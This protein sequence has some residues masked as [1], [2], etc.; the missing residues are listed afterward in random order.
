MLAR[1]F[2]RL[3]AILPLFVVAACSDSGLFN[4]NQNESATRLALRPYYG[5][6]DAAQSAVDINLIRLT[7]TVLPSGPTFVVDQ[8]VDPN[9]STW[10]LP[11]DVPPNSELSVLVELINRAPGGAEVVHFSG[12][13]PVI[14]VTSG[15]QPPTAPIP[16]FPGPAGNL[17]VSAVSISPRDQSLL[18][19]SNVS[20]A[21]TVTGGTN[22]QVRWSSNNESVAT[23]NA[24]GVVSGVRPGVA[25]ITAQ[26]GPRSDN[27]NVTVGARATRVEL[28]PTAATLT[29][30][31]QQQAFTARVLDSRNEV[32]PGLTVTFSIADATIASQGAPGVFRAL[33]NGK[34]TVTASA[35]QGTSTI[36]GS[37]DLTVDQRAT[38]IT[39]T[40]T[41]RVFESFGATQQFTI[42]ARDANGRPVPATAVTWRS[43]NPSVATVNASGLV[44]SVAPGTTN[45]IAESGTTSAQAEVTV[46]QRASSIT[47]T[48]SEA[49]LTFLGQTIA[50]AAQ[51]RD[52]NGNPMNVP[53]TWSA[54]S[55]NIVN[56]NPA[57]GVAFATGDG[58]GVIFATAEGGVREAITITVRRV[59]RRIILS[60]APLVLMGGQSRLVTA[61]VTDEGGQPIT[62]VGPIQWSST[63]PAVATVNSSGV[64]TGVGQGEARII[65]RHSSAE[66]I[67]DVTVSGTAPSGPLRANS[68]GKVLFI[69]ADCCGVSYVG[70]NVAAQSGGALTTANMAETSMGSIPT[71]LS[72]LLQYG[73]VFVWT[74]S[75]PSNPVAWGDRLKEYVDAGGKVVMA[76]YAFT[77]INDPWELQGGIMEPGYS[78]FALTND[79]YFATEGQTLDFATALTGSP[80][81]AGVTEF[82]YGGNSNY[83]KVVMAAGAIKVA[84]DNNG[85]PLIGIN[86]AGSVV[87]FNLYPGPVFGKSNGVWKA[88]ANALK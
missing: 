41:S 24:S 55:P 5:T 25:T 59:P 78:P 57:T 68:N 75:T 87:G 31:D 49:T 11:V 82:A 51:V 88:I 46:R 86:A 36:T 65:A 40:P 15:P 85:I 28:T 26:V 56:V 54:R 62:V 3:A 52:A 84:Q 29:S 6:V 61:S 77:N 18:E 1:R 20:L 33:R 69:H 58:E 39:I 63:N 35:I 37:A 83:S 14:R 45:I 66:G 16:V 64:V 27:I 60:P 47:I 32:V 8:P 76:V 21:A 43:T 4:P 34:T 23:V 81:L 38:S 22:P 80:I 50:L 30:I 79:R 9:A 73:A 70:A 44:T 53:V 17:G 71:P 10:D 19:G 74:N 48:P 42:E 7:I 12:V 72:T 13:L 67:L 2:L